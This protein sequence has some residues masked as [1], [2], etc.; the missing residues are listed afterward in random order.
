VDCSQ[1]VL[2]ATGTAQTWKEG[3]IGAFY[4][5]LVPF[6]ARDGP[7]LPNPGQH[8]HAHPL[9]KMLLQSG[10]RGADPHLVASG[11]SL[12]GSRTSFSKK[13]EPRGR[14]LKPFP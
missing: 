3:G 8:T 5:G 4:Q 13:C 7:W 2:W 1:S 10:A 12:S 6:Y 9:R 14:F 11:T